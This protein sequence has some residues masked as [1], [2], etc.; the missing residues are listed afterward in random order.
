[1]D[2]Q[3]MGLHLPGTQKALSALG[4]TVRLPGVAVSSDVNPQVGGTVEPHP[5]LSTAEEFLARVDV[6]V[7]PEVAEPSEG[8]AAVR[9]DVRSLARVVLLVDPE[10]EVVSKRL[11][12]LGTVQRFLAFVDQHVSPEVT[13]SH[14]S[15]PTLRAMLRSFCVDLFC[16]HPAFV[17]GEMLRVLRAAE[18]F[19]AR[20]NRAVRIKCGTLRNT[21]GPGIIL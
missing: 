18:R 17:L 1:M 21:I 6:L 9:T 4:A 19:L 14:K 3:Q 7:L 11:I 16:G 10:L 8:L 12:A 15:S 5:A 20:T 2:L 13:R